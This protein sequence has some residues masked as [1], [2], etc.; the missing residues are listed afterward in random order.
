MRRYFILFLAALLAASACRQAQDTRYFAP[1]VGFGSGRYAVSAGDGGVDIDL[2]LSR[3]ASQALQVGLQ[4]SSSLE[5]GLQYR[6]SSRTVDIAAG[7]Q[8][9]KLHVDL[10][11]DEIW[12]ESAWIEILLKP[13]ERYTVDPAK[14]ST[15]R[16]DIS[17]TILMP[18]FRLIPPAET[19]ET[20]PYLAETLSFQLE[21]DRETATN[22]EV[23]LDFGDLVYG[24]DYR[25][26]GSDVPGFTY[27]AGARSHV[28][29][30]EI[31]KKDLSGYDREATLTVVPKRGKYSVDPDYGSVP[32]HLSDP[33]VNFSPL[34]RS[35]A[36]QSGQGYQVRQAIKAA[37]GSWN[38]NTTV[39]IGV[40]SEGSN[41]LRN[42]RN[43]YDHP[44]FG[45]LANASVSQLFRFNDL[46]PLYVYPNETAI[47][48]YG[49]DQNHREF[50]PV[51]SL[52]RFVLD[53]GETRK[54]GIYL[55][56]P[57]TFI[58]FIGSY[59][60]W[61]EKVS[62]ENA[63]VKDSRA[64]K[65]DIFASTHPAITGRISVTLE[66]LEGRFDFSDSNA[67][68]VV[69]AW[70]SSDSDKFM[71]ADTANGKDPAATYAVSQEDGLWKVEY[72]L[73]PR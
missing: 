62:G 19:V 28:F 14:N 32:I 31:L 16:V 18:I 42:F 40:S 57:R 34:L 45:C 70:F 55:E 23:E 10:V 15:A 36:L 60:A 66:K 4:V 24:T 58:A 9:A 73:W 39:D 63:W 44:S 52:M 1:A 53:K 43:M 46:I 38:G 35:A 50:S 21:G 3:P 29:Q 59:A 51:D 56:K 47:L 13:G 17:K 64:N 49:N 65:G 20:N 69:T 68:V 8:E 22:L 71:Q 33:V 6:I 12:V 37:D 72:K 30:V 7:Q 26:K 67:P 54:G 25:I 27:P 41:Y 61:Q 11:D 2:Q 48:D 5:E